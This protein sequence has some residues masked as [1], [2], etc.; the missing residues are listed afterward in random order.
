MKYP[1]ILKGADFNDEK[2]KAFEV[3]MDYLNG[4][5]SKSN[6]AAGDHLTI[7]DI[8][9]LASASSMQ[10]KSFCLKK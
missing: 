6:Y 8:S 4:F 5:L 9:L 1:V 7:A 10:V 2:K 3:A